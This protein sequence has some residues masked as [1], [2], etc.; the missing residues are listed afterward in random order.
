MKV[1]F[2]PQRLL[3][4]LVFEEKTPNGIRRVLQTAGKK[5]KTIDMELSKVDSFGQTYP[6]EYYVSSYRVYNTDNSILDKAM[7]RN[8][9]STSNSETFLTT[10]N[11][12]GKYDKS[13]IVRN[14]QNITKTELTK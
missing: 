1:D 9:I 12:L 14:N 5:S 3:S 11:N 13:V 10:K 6:R 4:A 7:T 8:V 2:K